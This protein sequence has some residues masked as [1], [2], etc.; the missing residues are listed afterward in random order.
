[1]LPLDALSTAVAVVAF[2]EFTC[3]FISTTNQVRKDGSSVKIQFV[4]DST[5]TLIALNA[6]LRDRR[7]LIEKDDPNLTQL[8]EG[9]DRILAG[10]NDVARD[11]IELIA[12]LSSSKHG[13]MESVRTIFLTLLKKDKL[14]QIHAQLQAYRHDLNDYTIALLNEKLVKHSEDVSA[15]LIRLEENQKDALIG[16]NRI[17]EIVSFSRHTAVPRT[18]EAFDTITASELAVLRAQLFTVESQETTE[19][20]QHI[21][22]QKAVCAILVISDGQGNLSQMLLTAAESSD[23]LVTEPASLIEQTTLFERSS[24]GLQCHQTFSEPFLPVVRSVL[25]ALNFETIRLREESIAIAHERT[26]EWIFHERQSSD[27]HKDNGAPPYE[28]GFRHFLESS[29]GIFW[30]NGKPGSGKSTLMKFITNHKR[31]KD[32]LKVWAGSG[33]VLIATHFFLS[34]GTDLQGS[35]QG[36]LRSL[37][38]SLLSQDQTLI[39]IAFPQ[40]C[41]QFLQEGSVDPSGFMVSDMLAALKRILSAQPMRRKICLFIDGADEMS[42]PEEELGTLLNEIVKFPHVKAVVSSRPLAY[43]TKVV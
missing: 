41:R 19:N 39:P 33:Q 20:K 31:T 24:G 29:N 13:F 42:G 3:K 14:E 30:I 16:Q 25:G 6:G 5:A 34:R 27:D 40:A 22:D 4:R 37:L 17:L 11:L 35:F 32:F 8:E 9:I 43:F 7:R 2:V 23:A 36:L 18:V 21:K 15:R 28:A 12:Q 1:M 38:R 26:F 10:C